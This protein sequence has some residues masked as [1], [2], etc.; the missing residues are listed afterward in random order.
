MCVSTSSTVRSAC[1]A[2]R[3][4]SRGEK[5]RRPFPGGDT[6][7]ATAVVAEGH[8]PA[9]DGGGRFGHVLCHRHEVL[10]ALRQPM[11]VR[12]ALEEARAQALLELPQVADD[13]GLAETE[14]PRGAAQAAGLGDGEEDAKIVPLHGARLATSTA[15]TCS[16]SGAGRSAPGGFRGRARDGGLTGKEDTQCAT[17]SIW[18]TR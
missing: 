6:H 4:P 14:H 10:A 12:G 18:P 16:E 13:G 9:I 7:D 15:S 11:T 3:L 2:L 8:P 1:R 17:T 5:A